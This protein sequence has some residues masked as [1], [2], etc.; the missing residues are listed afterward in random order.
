MARLKLSRHL[1]LFFFFP[2]S[3]SF[4]PSFLLSKNLCMMFKALRLSSWIPVCSCFLLRAS[5]N[6]CFLT[7][8]YVCRLDGRWLTGWWTGQWMKEEKH[9]L[10]NE[11]DL[12]RVHLLVLISSECSLWA[13]FSCVKTNITRMLKTVLN[14]NR[15]SYHSNQ[16]SLLLLNWG[17]DTKKNKL[18]QWFLIKDDF[19]C[20]EH[21]ALSGDVFRC[22]TYRVVL[23]ASSG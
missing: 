23:L 2:L 5:F 14:W 4:P 11:T 3:S 8:H 13:Q 7:A 20:E 6:N 10:W 22:L 21:L 19:A 18:V 17:W 16:Q 12:G 9:K 1:S 15:Q